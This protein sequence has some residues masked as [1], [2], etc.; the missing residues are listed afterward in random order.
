MVRI[1]TYFYIAFFSFSVCL[2]QLEAAT[3]DNRSIDNQVKALL[4]RMT[5]EEKIGQMTQLTIQAV[6]VSQGT[7]FQR[8]KLDIKKHEETI[9]K[10]HVGSIFNAYDSALSLEDWNKLISTMQDVAIKHTRLKIP[11]IYGIDAIHGATYTIGATL[12]PQAL[13][14]AATFNPG[15]VKREGQ[16]AALEVS[17]SGIPWIFYPL[18]DIGR[19]PLWPRLLETYGEDV[20]LVSQM[21]K[22]YIQ[23]AQGDDISDTDK[24]ATC[25]KH[26]IGYSFP[27][28]GKDRTPA[29]IP[30]RMMK[31]YF[32]PPFQAGINAGSATIMAN[33]SEVN[34]ILGHSNYHLLTE[35]LRK[36]MKF[37]GFVVSDWGDIE[38]LY[39][40]DK[41][42]SS[43]EDAIRMAVMAGVDMS[44]VPSDFSFY[45]IL[46]KLVK[47]G[48]VPMSRINEA[49]SR[50]LR[51]K[52][53]LGLFSN[54]YPNEKLKNQF[55]AASSDE[56][57]LEASE[58]S[59][60]LVK[61][62]GNIFPL[63]K[64]KKVLVT[65][66]TADTLSTLNGG[67]TITWQEDE[68]SLYP[69]NKKHL[70][71]QLEAKSVM[72]M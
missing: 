24:V 29:W 23:D 67:W 19:Q 70:L 69:K 48:K 47:E 14:M 12:F 28:D 9:I 38:H 11:I 35:V 63:S 4:A 41:V 51:V 43:P 46:L 33:S 8:N 37:K 72:E 56:V 39:T 50:I 2:I 20:Y 62:K 60:T 17:A 61:N 53:E 32:L 49:V 42:A 10:Y 52:Y 40:R 16:I 7:A 22:S 27:L 26:F 58:E 54:P 55:A 5:L 66:P 1:A 30:E 25:L 21:G 6:S 31:E 64:N 36:K 34:G 15:L 18:M 59:I 3:K 65:D 57:N 13:N 71:K 44:M 45:D 68:E